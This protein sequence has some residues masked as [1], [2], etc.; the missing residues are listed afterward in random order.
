MIVLIQNYINQFQ[1]KIELKKEL[2]ESNFKNSKNLLEDVSKIE[3]FLLN[4][5]KFFSSA[6][7]QLQC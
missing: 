6:E 7:Y 3:K 4:K 1:S 5:N 2:F